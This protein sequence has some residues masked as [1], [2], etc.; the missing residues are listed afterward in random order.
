VTVWNVPTLSLFV[1]IVCIS[2]AQLAWSGTRL[3]WVLGMTVPALVIF[4]SLRR[5]ALAELGLGLAIVVAASARRHRW[6]TS[7]IIALTGGILAAAM[8][9][10]SVGAKIQARAKTANPFVQST[11]RY[12]VTN[13]SH[14]DDILDAWDQV[15]AHPVE[16]LGV[17]VYYRADRTAEWKTVSGDVHNG[18]LMVWLKFGLLGLAT[19]VVAHTLLF[20]ALAARLHA[21]S[22]GEGALALGIF[23]FFVAQFVV[24]CAIFPWPYG[25]WG[26]AV[27]IGMLVAAAWRVQP[28]VDGRS[29]R[30]SAPTSSGVTYAQ[31]RR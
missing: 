29:S 17:G 26:Q 11:S 28:A 13:Q 25:S 14:I 2:L 4:F 20:R 7:T 12:A 10:T 8:L 18:I 19:Y 5:F 21:S 30:S 31:S 15:K 23:A 22:D 3:V 6:R 1:A 16:G 24:T 9:T 27:T